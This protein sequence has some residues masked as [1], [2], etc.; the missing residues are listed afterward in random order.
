MGNIA[1]QRGE[2]R[3][4]LQLYDEAAQAAENAHIQ[5]YLA[6]AR[7][8][9]AY[10]SLL[11]GRVDA[12]QQA[13]TQGVKVAEAY[14][15]LAALLHLY[16]TQGEIHLYLAEWTKAAES[17]QLGLDLAEELG[18]LERQ[19][20]YRGG[21]A[22]A[23]R[24]E[25]DLESG[26]AL[27]EEAIALIADQGYWHLRTRLKL[28]LAEIRFDRQ[29]YMALA[30]LLEEALA[31]TRSHQRTLLLVQAQR[32]NAGLLA[33]TGDWP[34]SDGLF[35]DAL[36]NA[37]GLGLDLEVAR[38]QAAWGAALLHFSPTGER[39]RE[40]LATARAVF[41]TCSAR[42]DLAALPPAQA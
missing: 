17:F 24:G 13:A 40:L 12:A 4:A 28:W 6:L 33:A 19:A 20:G 31:I 41:V 23:A 30:P 22:L 35:A 39:G 10:H 26:I 37:A 5:Y 9:Y 3:P 21:L 34:A 25:G 16:S 38:V 27:L 36:R 2:L 11:L 18:N 32:L 7:N 42:A 15:L 1:A 14:E 8:N 29:E